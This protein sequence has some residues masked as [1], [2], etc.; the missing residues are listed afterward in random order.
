MCKCADAADGIL[1]GASF[2]AMIG[3]AQCG[4][5]LELSPRGSREV[6]GLGLTET[7]RVAIVASIPSPTLILERFALLDALAGTATVTA[8]AG[9][10]SQLHSTSLFT[11][12]SMAV[13]DGARARD[14][15]AGTGSEAETR[16]SAEVR[17]WL[18][19][20]RRR[21]GR[22]WL[23]F[24]DKNIELRYARDCC[25][26]NARHFAVSTVLHLAAVAQQVCGIA[27]AAPV[28]V[29][30]MDAPPDAAEIS[31]SRRFTLIALAVYC[32]FAAA[33]AMVLLAV[34][35]W[36]SATVWTFMTPLVIMKMAHM[37]VSGACLYKLPGIWSWLV[38]YSAEMSLLSG[39]IGT[40]SFRGIVALSSAAFCFF[41]FT[42][43]TLLALEPASFLPA[44][45]RLLVLACGA[46]WISRRE[47]YM[48]RTEWRLRKL[49]KAEL[50]ALR[51][52]L[53]DLLPWDVAARLAEDPTARPRQ[54]R[55]AAVLQA[56]KIDT[57]LSL[58]IAR[59][60]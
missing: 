13:R 3:A 43:P 16:L 30:Q 50:R 10:G 20:P 7:F 49:Y 15:A 31:A 11:F 42:V 34:W 29:Y 59:N 41:L 60:V 22:A 46:A 45:A 47:E 4:G 33:F 23:K 26:R 6:K 40:V 19:D 53:F 24:K 2:A 44:I 18:S 14:C 39:W 55:E 21:I 1:C 17:R 32:G 54:R 5:V 35:R 51:E 52:R 38:I 9:S 56:C 28:Y 48:H 57:S 36:R 12:T 8:V 27:F 58:I 25:K 37:G